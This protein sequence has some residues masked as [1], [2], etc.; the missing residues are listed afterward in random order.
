MR[1]S[2]KKTIIN[3]GNILI[4]FHLF[5]VLVKVG[6]VLQSTN[7]KRSKAP[8]NCEMDWLHQIVYSFAQKLENVIGKEGEDWQDISFT[9]YLY[10]PGTKIS[11]HNDGD[12]SGACIFYIHPDWN[13]H[14]GGELLIA[15]TPKDK[16]PDQ[17]DYMSRKDH[18][19]FLNHYGLG[20]YITPLPNRLVFTKG[21]LWHCINRV[22][23]AAGDNIRCSVVAFFKKIKDVN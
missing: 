17:T 18:S 3:S 9:P 10:P 22:D 12:F 19:A 5:I 8:F 16:V 14:W 20:H 4:I 21:D 15:K 13:V 11:W 6:D 7:Y 2:L 1:F 23:Q